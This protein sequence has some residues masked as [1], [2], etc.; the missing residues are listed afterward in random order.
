MTIST[1]LQYMPGTSPDSKYLVLARN[2]AI[3]LGI[4]AYPMMPGSRFGRLGKTYLPIRIHSTIDTPPGADTPT[5][6]LPGTNIVKLGNEPKEQVFK[7]SWPKIEFET[8]NSDRAATTFGMFLRGDFFANPQPLVDEL[9]TGIPFDTLAGKL[10]DLA[11]PDDLVLAKRPLIAW[12]KD[13][14]AEKIAEL[15]TLVDAAGK[16]DD[17]GPGFQAVALKKLYEQHVAELTPDKPAKIE[18]DDDDDAF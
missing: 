6:T 2:G 8:A 13:Q 16:L 4:R 10:L 7:N 11:E 18:T 5:G 12:L 17:D 3:A 14:Y 15:Q 1:E 9:L